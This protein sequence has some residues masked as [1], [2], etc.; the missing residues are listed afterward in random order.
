[1]T[2][3]AQQNFRRL[4]CLLVRENFSKECEKAINKQINMELKAC[5]HYLA[6][7][8]HFDR[9][10]VAAP[11]VFKFLNEASHEER[12]HAEMFMEYMN[13]RGGT[14]K[15]EALEAPKAKIETAKDAM[16]EAL[17]MEKEVNEA[18]LEAHAIASKNN[19]PNMCD[20][21]E[22]NFLQ[23]QVDAIKQLA[24]FIR[25]IERSECDLGNYL[26]DKYLAAN[27]G[28]MHKK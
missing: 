25:Q 11:G 3:L 9:S 21:I 19:D 15:V 27:S 10:E 2:S 4:L 7:A 14:I 16:M 12:K 24:D 18:L 6:M 26:F 23:E 22:A 13:K 20:F 5:H 17:N 28:N 1:M 8:F